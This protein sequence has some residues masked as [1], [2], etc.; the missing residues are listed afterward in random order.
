MN[1][2]ERKCL[3]VGGGPVAERKVKSILECEGLVRIVSPCITSTLADLS[4]QKRLEW[5]ARNYSEVDLAG[6]F[7][8]FI[9][10]DDYQLNRTIAQDCHQRMIMVNVAD[11]PSNCDFFVPSLLRRDSLAVA[12]STEGRSPLFSRRL[13]E[14]LEELIP[15]DYGQLVDGLGRM[16]DHI[17][18]LVEDTNTRQAVYRLLLQPDILELLRNNQEEKARERIEACIS[19]WQD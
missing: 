8:A 15:Q 19:S 1:L 2:R 6:V 4:A 17:K 13:R 11:D 12:I 10:T 5:D 9:C 7:L 16:R 3:V 18:T 14:E